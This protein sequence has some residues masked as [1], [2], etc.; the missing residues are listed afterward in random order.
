MRD[1]PTT[2]AMIVFV[3]LTLIFGILALFFWNQLNTVK[4]ENEAAKS[5]AS[6]AQSALSKANQEAQSLKQI[7]GY[8]QGA[9]LGTIET[10]HA[11]DVENY[12]RT[13][14]GEQEQK[15]YLP[16]LRFVVSQ[17]D[18]AQKELDS[19]NRAK[20][21]LTEKFEAL[22][23]NTEQQIRTFSDNAERAQNELQ[24]A[25]KQYADS[26]G[27]RDKVVKDIQGDFNKIKEDSAK[28]IELVKTESAIVNRNLETISQAN[29]KLSQEIQ[30]MKSP[31]IEKADGKIISVNQLS[32]SVTINIGNASGLR[33]G[34][35]FGVFDPENLNMA[36]AESK[37]NI[38]IVQLLGPDK[39]EGRILSTVI[40]NPIQY[41]D[42][43]YTPVWKPGI[44]PRFVLS[45][46]MLVSGFGSRATDHAI[47]EDDLED[48]IRLIMSNGGMVDYYMA[49]DGTIVKVENKIDQRGNV[50]IVSRTP[51]N[52]I[53]VTAGDLSGASK[54]KE[55]GDQI[56][57]ETAFLIRGTGDAMNNTLMS[58][59]NVLDEQAKIHGIRTIT[60]PELLRRMGWRNSTPSKGYGSRAN[61][62]DIEPKPTRPAK[63]SPG[64]VSQLY[65]KKQEMSFDTVRSPGN[66]AGIYDSTAASAKVSPGTVSPLY[67]K[68]RR[69]VNASSGT[70]SGIYGGK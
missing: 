50:Q 10:A 34:T 32:G 67:H 57:Q 53:A 68:D 33:P 17:R 70:V 54:Q 14:V 29:E 22:E 15:G 30:G 18:A 60:L 11:K 23:K 49:A 9:E 37:G 26:I 59:M 4:Q 56:L 61:E 35:T 25:Q 8:P 55:V 69:P 44:H 65:S 47:M 1:Q 12:G 48:V 24:E 6:E 2:I 58:N 36:E 51:A 62:T 13:L 41:G 63:V 42:I 27:Q 31:Y 43:I 7:L 28:A 66:V 5:Q 52:F 21:E 38:E 3:V 64:T 39:A 45:G 20:I 46:R 19:E 40:T 16:L